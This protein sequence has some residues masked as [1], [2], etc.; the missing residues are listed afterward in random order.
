MPEDVGGEFD[1]LNQLSSAEDDF[2]VDLMACGCRLA[3]GAGLKFELSVDDLL[4]LYNFDEHALA[5]FVGTLID[6]SKLESAQIHELARQA[7]QGKIR[8]KPSA[9]RAKPK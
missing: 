3:P 4:R 1:L 6:A 7:A 5:A 2:D 9:F 8:E